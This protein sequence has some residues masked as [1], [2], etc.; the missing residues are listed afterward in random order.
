MTEQTT[1]PTPTIT[2]EQINALLERV[3]CIGSHIEGTTTTLLHA[4]LDDRFYLGSAHSACV[5]VENFNEEKGLQ[6][7]RDKLF[8]QITD[9]L[10][11]LEG[12]RLY[13]ELTEIEAERD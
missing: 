10:W 11:E 8:A 13:Q 3:Q 9:K 7:A 1:A 6:I 12:Y 4:F 5:S 2:Q